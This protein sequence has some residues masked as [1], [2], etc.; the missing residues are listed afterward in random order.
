MPES[1]FLIVLPENNKELE[2]HCQNIADVSDCVNRYIKRCAAP[3]EREL[4]TFTVEGVLK[5]S[6]H[7]CSNESSKESLYAFAPCLNS[8]IPLQYDCGKV[9][10][11]TLEPF[12]ELPNNR[13]IV[14]ICCAYKTW[15]NCNKAITVAKCGETAFNFTISGSGA[16]INPGFSKQ[17]CSCK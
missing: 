4:F 17:I 13:R 11:H 8:A 6:R 9:L 5:F 12:I 10:Q 7:Y 16:K 3:I 14:L 1:F 15:E 2:Q